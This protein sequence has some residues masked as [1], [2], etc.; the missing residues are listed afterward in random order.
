M[1]K[2]P[3]SY[4]LPDHVRQKFF[5]ILVETPEENA[6][7]P[8]PVCR[9]DG[10][11]YICFNGN[12]YSAAVVSYLLNVGPIP[13]G[14]KV[15]RKCG[16]RNCVNPPHLTPG[17]PA[18]TTDE[19]IRRLFFRKT[20]RGTTTKKNFSTAAITFGD[21]K[22][23]KAFA[24]MLRTKET[25]M[26][27]YLIMR[28]SVSA[29]RVISDFSGEDIYKVCALR[30]VLVQELNQVIDG[31]QI[32]PVH[33]GAAKVQDLKV[34]PEAPSPTHKEIR[35]FN[36]R[37]LEVAFPHE[38]SG[39]HFDLPCLEWTGTRNKSGYGVFKF[40][41]RRCI[42]SRVALFHHCDNRACVEATHLVPGTLEDNVLDR[43]LKGRTAMGENHGT[44]TQPQSVRK[45][46]QHGMSVFTEDEVVL[47]RRTYDTHRKFRGILGCLTK[48]LKKKRYAV[49][50]IATRTTWKHIPED[51]KPEI[52]A[53]PIELLQQHTP[54][55]A[56]GDDHKL[57]KLSNYRVREMRFLAAQN[58]GRKG[59]ARALATRFGVSRR[60]VSAI[61]SREKRG[62]IVDNFDELGPVEPLALD[63]P[64]SPG[65]DSA[66]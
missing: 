18:A 58:Q 36:R 34:S 7:W 55:W 10:H 52:T 48:H 32:D 37:L 38:I 35:A 60:L 19:N 50:C 64:V 62:E 40:R 13:T 29:Q 11:P 23:V 22:D 8:W 41:G 24:K 16:H 5:R 61:L 28:F 3:L 47:I 26:A 51:A 27:S 63:A 14:M 9:P 56:R 57:T 4:P 31:E 42:A 33:L 17:Q 66:D 49:W 53:L 45:G 59:V 21:I 30:R 20:I 1:K 25:P 65:P 46:E 39:E 12:Q 43:K 15:V 6:C 2:P 44:H 54:K